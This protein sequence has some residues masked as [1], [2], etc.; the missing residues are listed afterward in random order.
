MAGDVAPEGIDFIA[1]EYSST[2]YPLLLVACEVSGTVAVMQINEGYVEKAKEITIFHT[3]DVHSRVDNYSKVKAYINNYSNKLLVDAGD[4]F[5]GQSIATLEFGS[6]I[7]KILKAM[8]YSAMVPGNHDFNYGQDRLAELGEESGVKILAANIKKNG[9]AKYDEYTIEEINGVKIG[10]FGIATPET[11]YK[12]N[13]NNVIGLDFGTK[14]SIIED[15]KNMVSK[16]KGEGANIIIALSHL[17]IDSDSKVK[18]TDIA[19]VVDGIDLIIDGHSHSILEDYSE[20]N[21]NNETKIAS[22]GE[23]LNGLGEVTVSFDENLQVENIDLKT[24]DTN[25]LVEE[26]TEISNLINSIKDNQQDILNEVVGSTPIK[27]EGSR[28]L[29]RSGHTNLGRLIT[30]AM[31]NETGA[32]IA[33]TNGGGIRD[34]IEAGDITKDSI[35]KVLPF[36]NYIV[37]KKVKGSDIVAALEHGMVEG[38]G[39]FAHFAGITVETKKE[40]DEEGVTRHKVL[41][42]KINGEDLDLNKEYVLATNDFMAVGGDGYTMFN[43]YPTLNEYSALD[44]SLIKYI[45][46]VGS[47]G[48]I[49]IDKEERLV[50]KDLSNETT[51]K[52]EV[53]GNKNNEVVINPSEDKNENSNNDGEL[54]ET[55][56]ISTIQIFAFVVVMLIGRYMLLKE[57]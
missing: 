35:I 17:G 53:E 4:T 32:D 41:S 5:H 7:A 25:T 15:A 24:V 8:G 2:G 27:L 26:D 21:N 54:P 1:A 28:E 43:D 16:L 9:I 52:D 30:S 39:S 36:G 23:Y 20:F 6:S 12:T 14:D 42:V 18:S 51:D 46:E 29:V 48:I 57:N 33:I 31:L 11:A 49:A 19:K 3:N 55:G 50:V 22:T 40:S 34:S 13:P 45:E 44:E 37:T 38:S 10:I 56:G 47:E